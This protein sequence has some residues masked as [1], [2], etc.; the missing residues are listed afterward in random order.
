MTD[1]DATTPRWWR[2]RRRWSPRGIDSGS[3]L[4]GEPHA[5]ATVKPMIATIHALRRPVK[6]TEQNVTRAIEERGT[7]VLGR[8]T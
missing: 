1:V 6:S 4:S 7:I 3:N 8:R 2:H 5:A